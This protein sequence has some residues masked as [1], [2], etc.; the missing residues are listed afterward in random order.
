MLTS[1]AAALLSLTSSTAQAA[2]TSSGRASASC[3]LL[4]MLASSCRLSRAL[5]E[6]ASFC[7][8]HRSSCS[9]NLSATDD[10]CV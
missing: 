10:S 9:A 4:A 5:L 2:S 7:M 3:S 6:R 1:V 8:P